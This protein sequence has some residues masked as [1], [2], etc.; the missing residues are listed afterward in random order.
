MMYQYRVCDRGRGVTMRLSRA[1][2]AGVFV[3]VSVLAILAGCGDQPSEQPKLIGG[4]SGSGGLQTSQGNGQAVLGNIP[5]SWTPVSGSARTD[6][7]GFLS[8]TKIEHTPGV[9]RASAVSEFTPVEPSATSAT[10]KYVYTLDL[11]ESTSSPG[12]YTGTM[13]L[14]WTM[15]INRTGSKSEYVAKYTAS[16]VAKYD[17]GTEKI[18]GGLAKGTAQTSDTFTAGSDVMKPVTSTEDFEWEFATQ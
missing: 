8:G 4:S 13:T 11:S 5:V 16:V 3:L 17:A 1:G 7:I 15:T 2:A 6:P 14:E 9:L 12:E 10:G 18:T